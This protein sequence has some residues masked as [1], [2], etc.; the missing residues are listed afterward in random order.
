MSSAPHSSAESRVSAA[1]GLFG[2]LLAPTTHRARI[3]WTAGV[4]VVL[5]IVVGLIIRTSRFDFPVVQFF[6]GY[7]QGAIG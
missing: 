4:G 5:V 7:H 2:A 3:I 6:N 1:R